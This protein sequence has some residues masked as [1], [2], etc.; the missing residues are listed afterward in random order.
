MT[1]LDGSPFTYNKPEFINGPFLA[2]SLD[3]AD[4]RLG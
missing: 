4:P 1:A 3:P 2:H